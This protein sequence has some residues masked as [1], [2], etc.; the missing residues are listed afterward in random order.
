MPEIEHSVRPAR[1]N[2]FHWLVVV[3]LTLSVF[4]LC[5]LWGASEERSYVLSIDTKPTNPISLQIDVAGGLIMFVIF[6]QN[7]HDQ[8]IGP[9][10]IWTES[11]KLVP[12][13]THDLVGDTTGI[14]SNDRHTFGPFGFG[15]RYEWG[16]MF[17]GAWMPFWAM[18]L[19]CL[20]ALVMK[21]W[22]NKLPEPTAVGA[23]VAIH[24]ASRRW[25]SFLR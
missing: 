9:P 6:P 24:A 22:R 7:I 25:F 1:R 20:S 11:E 15:S 23:A 2:F 18:V 19:L 17:Y 4:I 13:W 10:G 3:C 21:L 12:S 14:L 5:L 8:D 16:E